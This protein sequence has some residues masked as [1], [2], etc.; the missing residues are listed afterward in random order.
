MA[1][2]ERYFK[3]LYIETL[4]NKLEEERNLITSL[5]SRDININNE[6]IDKLT[7]EV[8]VKIYEI[9]LLLNEIDS[10]L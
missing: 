3:S 9:E 7:T 5:M 2:T 4:R 1:E 8:G 10:L 6:K